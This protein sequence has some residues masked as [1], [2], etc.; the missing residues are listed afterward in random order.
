[1]KRTAATNATAAAGGHIGLASM[2]GHCRISADDAGSR[3]PGSIRHAMELRRCRQ[4]VAP[5]SMSRTPVMM[6]PN[7]ASI[8]GVSRSLKKT[9]VFRGRSV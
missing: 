1:M 6:S 3:I 8:I 5:N 9:R 2:Q 7:S 4:C